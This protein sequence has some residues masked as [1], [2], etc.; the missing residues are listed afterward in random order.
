MGVSSS[1]EEGWLSLA[2]ALVLKSE[3]RT[4]LS[5]TGCVSKAE[6]ETL[7]SHLVGQF[8]VVFLTN[9]A[10]LSQEIQCKLQIL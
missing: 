7:I 3:E 10:Y 1:S 4:L 8:E 2:S 9:M 5:F 6:E